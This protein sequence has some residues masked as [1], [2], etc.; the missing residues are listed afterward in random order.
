VILINF[1]E[2]N[3]NYA[4]IRKEIKNN[5]FRPIKNTK[6]LDALNDDDGKLS[7]VKMPLQSANN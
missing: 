2:C 3:G 5:C 7:R 4:E 1:F 6:R